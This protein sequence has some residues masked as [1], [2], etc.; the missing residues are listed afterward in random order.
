MALIGLVLLIAAAAVG[1]DIAA[2][3]DIS[4]DID[5][6]GQTFATTA[7]GVLVA[8]VVIGLVGALG[9]LLMTHGVSRR[10]RVR[11]ESRMTTE[12][13]DRLAAAYVHEHEAAPHVSP[14][15]ADAIDLRD[16]VRAREERREDTT[17]DRDRITTF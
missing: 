6:F 13:R 2:Q 11:R 15:D 12:E 8:G 9:L 1:V 16:R 14:D 17:L 10:R 4:L 3:N 7:G 5:A